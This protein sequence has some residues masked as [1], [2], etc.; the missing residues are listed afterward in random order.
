MRSTIHSASASFVSS[1]SSS[2]PPGRVE[3]DRPVGVDLEAGVGGAHVVG[4]H[5]VDALGGELGR[6]VLA[7][8]LGLGREA[9]PRPGPARLR[10]PSSARMSTVGS[11]TI[12]GTP[13]PFF[14]FS[15]RD[16]LGPEVGDRRRHDDDVAVVG[17][18]EHGVAHLLGGLDRAPTSTP[19]ATGC[20]DG[21]R[22]ARRARPAARAAARD[23]VAHL[24]RRA[25]A[26]VAHRVDRL[27]R[28]PPA[29]TS[30]RA[31]DER[32]GRAIRGA[33]SAACDDAL[34][35]GEP[36]ERRRR[37]PRGGRLRV[38]ARA[39][40]ARAASRGSP[41]PP[42]APTSRCASPGTRAPARASRAASRSAGR[43]RCRP[44]TCRSAWRSRAR[45][46]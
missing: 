29:V 28:V 17:A 36:A 31:P 34:R 19:A 21:G 8:A 26:D 22:R 14:S 4:D 12:S 11:S 10:A 9:R 18:R 41:A 43:R 42:R 37:R 6:R 25:V 44:R 5:E 30:T 24:P 40:R 16:R 27:S 38:R 46:R 23:R 33:P 15:R 2:T 32:T 39:R 7:D 35:I 13:S 1:G 3:H 20:A 45:R